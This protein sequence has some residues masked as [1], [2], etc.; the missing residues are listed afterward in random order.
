MKKKFFLKD[1]L[2]GRV[3]G[4]MRGKRKR[5]E[6]KRD[7]VSAYFSPKSAMAGTRPGLWSKARNLEPNPN[8]ACGHQEHNYLAHHGCLPGLYQQE[9][10]PGSE[11]QPRHS[12]KA[13]RYVGARPDTCPPQSPISKH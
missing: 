2:R 9:A 5:G 1:H 4:E 13:H 3:K 10:G 11:V 6:G 12:H 8:L 7:L